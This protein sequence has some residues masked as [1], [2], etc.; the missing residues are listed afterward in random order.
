MKKVYIS[1]MLLFLVI[2]LTGCLPSNRFHDKDM[3][4]YIEEYEMTNVIFNDGTSL[5]TLGYELYYNGYF[6][7]LNNDYVNPAYSTEWALG[8]INGASK[9]LFVPTRDDFEIFILDNPFPSF[10]DV[11]EQIS[12][13]NQDDNMCE[14]SLLEGMSNYKQFQS[15]YDNSSA[16]I[17][18]D[19][20]ENLDMGSSLSAKLGS[21]DISDTT[22][23]VRL[24]AHSN[25]IY[26][27][28][29]NDLRNISPEEVEIIELFTIQ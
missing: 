29:H 14:I 21:C 12:L 6:D 23:V 4:Y 7:S 2:T 16:I 28:A 10:S 1:I 25:K 13:Y 24:I 8:E 19:Y 22:Y 18:N 3:D 27:V 11:K 26:V 20:F 9:I 17:F 5:D 15:L